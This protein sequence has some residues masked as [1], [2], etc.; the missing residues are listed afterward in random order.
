MAVG[1][2]TSMMSGLTAEMDQVTMAAAQD[3]VQQS[4]TASVANI[5]KSGASNVKDASRGS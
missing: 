5:A 2:A 3:Q 1:S 4:M